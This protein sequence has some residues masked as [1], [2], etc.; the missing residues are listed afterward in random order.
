MKMTLIFHFTFPSQPAF[1]CSKSIIKTERHCANMSNVKQE[2]HQV[3]C[4]E[5]SFDKCAHL[6]L[7]WLLSTLWIYYLHCCSMSFLALYLSFHLDSLHLHPDSLHS[8]TDSRH[9]T[10]SVPQFPILAF[11]DSLLGLQSLRI[12]SREIINC[13]SWTLPFVTTT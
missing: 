11:T 8:N 1:T 12:Y 4:V 5:L 9:F 2:R 6:L 13:F 10:H 3:K 7:F